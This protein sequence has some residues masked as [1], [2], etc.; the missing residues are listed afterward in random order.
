MKIRA[1][2]FF[3]YVLTSQSLFA[4]DCIPLS[5]GEQVEQSTTI[6]AGEYLE[7][8]GMSMVFRK[9][10]LWKGQKSLRDVTQITQSND[11]CHKMKDLV[12][13]DVYIVF[14]TENGIYNCSRTALF[15]GNGDIDRLDNWKKKS[16]LYDE[17]K[18]AALLAKNQAYVQAFEQCGQD[19]GALLTEKESWFLSIYLAKNM[20]G[21][22][23]VDK[24]VLFITG[25]SA[26]QFGTKSDY[27]EDV[28][29]WNEKEAKI[30]SRLDWLTPEEK[31]LSGGYD[32]AIT[33]WVKIFT[34]KKRK[35]MLKKA[36]KEKRIENL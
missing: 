6:F 5:F 7:T 17:E 25:S 20:E 16:L 24:N 31:E 28:R 29:K 30:S 1:I 18:Y 2:L 14:A 3:A 4:C 21:R 34:K 32:A 10:K 15:I 23:L 26:S 9:I 33:Y 8:E 27:F 13:G 11:S 19:N 36:G 35:K 12:A 22:S